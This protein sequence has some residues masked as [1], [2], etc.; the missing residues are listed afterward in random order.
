MMDGSY[1]S[2]DKK[3]EAGGDRC[4]KGVANVGGQKVTFFRNRLRDFEFAR[5][6]ICQVSALPELSRAF[7]R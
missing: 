7:S 3:T 1:R 4:S 2:A 5:T 6:T